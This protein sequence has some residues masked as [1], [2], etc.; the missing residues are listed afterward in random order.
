MTLKKGYDLG[1]KRLLAIAV[2]LGAGVVHAQVIHGT[3]PSVTS[4]GGAKTMFSPP[5][6]PASV[7]SLGPGAWGGGFGC[8]GPGFGGGF[9]F[10][11]NPTFQ[12]GFGFRHHRHFGPLLAVPL[13]VP[14]YP[15]YPY[16]PYAAA[17]Y[18]TSP[19]AQAVYVEEE[20]PPAPTIFERRGRVRPAERDQDRY[21]EHAFQ[22]P[23]RAQERESEA[24]ERPAQPVEEQET[25][26]LVFRD[27][28]RLEV[29]NYAIVGPTLYDLNGRGTHK[30]LLANLDL[31]ATRKLNDE[32]GVEFKIPGR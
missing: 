5:G 7:T 12:A 28:R 10:G 27:G 14:Y 29:H 11:H 21:G 25:T 13:Y 18:Q 3:P 17:M 15:V 19:D 26:I 2:L 30:V 22:E 31:D 1:V 6:I 20:D 16:Y 24:E 8:C 9:R 4:L 23:R 32:R